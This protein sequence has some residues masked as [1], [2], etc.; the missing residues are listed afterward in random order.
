M[1][2]YEDAMMELD[3]QMDP[4]SPK[5]QAFAW[6][7]RLATGEADGAMLAEFERWRDS[8]PRNAKALAEARALWLL[9]GKPLEAQYAPVMASQPS[10]HRQGRRMQRWRP[11]LATAAT[12]MLMVGLGTQWLSSWRYDQVT[13]TGEQR[14]I[15]LEDGSTLWLNTG[16]A[17]DIRVDAERRHVRLVRGEAY[18]DVAHDAQRPF[19]VDAGQGQVR[20][21][22][23]A[24]G[25]RRNGDNVVVTVERGRVQVSGGGMP[26]VVLGPNQTVRV[27]AGDTVKRTGF[28]N[29]E[30]HL[31]WRTGRL[32]FE[33]RP[34][35]EILSEL[36]RY[37]SRIVL[38]RYP[39]AGRTRVSS[40]IDLA[41]LDEWYDT[42]DQTLPV[43]VTRFGPVVWIRQAGSGLPAPED[44]A[45]SPPAAG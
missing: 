2:E 38:V 1:T 19:T 21:L 11:L 45:A 43:E 33:N 5:D 6:L 39:Q 17:A 18:F 42:L 41:R 10:R 36:K 7:A 9:I 24:F 32:Q 4:D 31:S 27:R 28:V 40:V 22:G 29:A 23:T 13:A 25:V 30:Q 8:D 15:A 3:V 16:S 37:D 14:T 44:R 12:L 20:V 26:A 34:I 35:S